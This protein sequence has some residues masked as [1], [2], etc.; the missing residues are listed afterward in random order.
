MVHAHPDP[1]SFGLD[2]GTLP[3]AAQASQ[4]A[5]RAAYIARVVAE[6]PPLSAAQTDHLSGLLRA[7]VEKNATPFIN[8]RQY[9][10]LEYRRH[11]DNETPGKFGFF[12]ADGEAA[13]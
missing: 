4:A 1:R 5:K 9:Q 12:T 8:E 11:L 2:T 6:A 10:S 13:A 7:G 3:S